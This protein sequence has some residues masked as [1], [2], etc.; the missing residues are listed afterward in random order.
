MFLDVE[1]YK[2]I[3]KLFVFDVGILGAMLDLSYKDLSDQ[4]SGIS[5]GYYAENF[6]AYEFAAAGIPLY[7]WQQRNAEIEFL[8][9]TQE[10]DIIP[11]EVKNGK[12]TKAKS[13]A[14]YIERYDPACTIKLVGKVGGTDSS[15]LVMPLYYAGKMGKLCG[16]VEG[17]KS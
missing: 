13:L 8:H 16:A 2:P 14:S 10:A 6:V 7:S 11:V 15:H 3:F 5:K 17:K 1:T 4:R 9:V 12:R